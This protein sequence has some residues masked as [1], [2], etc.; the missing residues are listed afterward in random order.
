[1]SSD[2]ED[3]ASAHLVA[4][5]RLAE[6]GATARATGDE[7]KAKKRYRKAVKQA[8]AACT[9]GAA[10]AAALAEDLLTRVEQHDAPAEELPELRTNIEDLD[11][12]ATALAEG[13]VCL[14]EEC[15]HVT[16]AGGMMQSAYITLDLV[17][18][19]TRDQYGDDAHFSF[20]EAARRCK[21]QH[22]RAPRRELGRGTVV[23]GHE[24]PPRLRRAPEP[25]VPAVDRPRSGRRRQAR[26]YGPGLVGPR[27]GRA[28]V[29][30]RRRAALPRWQQRPAGARFELLRAARECF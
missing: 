14:L 18:A 8:A 22:R 10:A 9:S 17:R 11:D 21:G 7:K 28:A 23:H 20:K 16:E 27:L 13:G 26:L 30:R 19:A 3:E 12:A 15:V 1:M 29:A 4:A 24:G 25:G 2:D 6:A 5:V